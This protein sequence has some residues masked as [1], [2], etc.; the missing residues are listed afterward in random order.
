M[1][2]QSVP[3]REELLTWSLTKQLA[4]QCDIFDEQHCLIFSWFPFPLTCV[5]H[6]EANQLAPTLLLPNEMGHDLVW[7][8]VIMDPLFSTCS[9]LDIP[10]KTFLVATLQPNLALELQ[11]EWNEQILSVLK[12]V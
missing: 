2:A 6:K 12:S 7:R 3:D 1:I 11:L 10:I 8:L 9:Q 4:L 5:S